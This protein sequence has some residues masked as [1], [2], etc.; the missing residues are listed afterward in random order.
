LRRVHITRSCCSVN[1]W[2]S[3]ANRRRTSW[4]W[5]RRRRSHGT[6]CA[7]KCPPAPELALASHFALRRRQ[8]IC[9][10]DPA[11]AR[12]TA[13]TSMATGVSYGLAMYTGML[14]C[15]GVL[16]RMAAVSQVPHP[17]RWRAFIHE[18]DAS[19]APANQPARQ[20]S[21][22]SNPRCKPLPPTG[23]VRS[24]ARAA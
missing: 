4:T 2:L 15:W 7:R 9:H 24:A 12:R 13:G 23:A 19:D 17:H 10:R 11:P 8:P 14:L 18:A 21:C 1:G 5:R 16:P 6:S 22:P 20:S 3:S